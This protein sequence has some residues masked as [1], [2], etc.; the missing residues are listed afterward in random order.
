VIVAYQA[1]D[2]QAMPRING[3]GQ[4]IPYKADG[5]VATPPVQ[6]M[7]EL[8]RWLQ[9]HGYAPDSFQWLGWE[10]GLRQRRQTYTHSP[11]VGAPGSSRSSPLITCDYADA[12]ARFLYEKAGFAVYCAYRA[13]ELEVDER[14]D[15]A[16]Q[17]AVLTFWVL[18]RKKGS[19]EYAF[20]GAKYAIMNSLRDKSPYGCVSLDKGHDD[21]DSPCGERLRVDNAQHDGWGESH[22][23]SDAHLRS[24]V[25]EP[26]TM[27]VTRQAR[28]E[29]RWK[30][31]KRHLEMRE[32][33]K[34]TDSKPKRA[35]LKRLVAWVEMDKERGKVAYIFPL[36]D[37]NLYIPPG[38]FCIENRTIEY[39]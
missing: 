8:Y 23:I 22:W 6:T 26:F 15:G 9:G 31:S 21:H 2:A 35:L 14:F 32:T 25:S 34:G 19:E 18:Y 3:N 7:P 28:N 33:L 39:G 29:Y 1:D 27:P 12:E 16:R 24:V 11:A 37:A 13:F 30:R 4:L 10:H 5:Q 20:V 38:E 36:R 17:E